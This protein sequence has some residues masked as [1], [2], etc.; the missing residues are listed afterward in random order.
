[1]WSFFICGTQGWIH[2]ENEYDVAFNQEESLVVGLSYRELSLG[3]SVTYGIFFATRA[4]V[5]TAINVM[6]ALGHTE[7]IED[8]E[9]VRSARVDEFGAV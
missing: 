7:E 4:K 5:P 2:G 1:L 8:R 6:P 3:L 9:N